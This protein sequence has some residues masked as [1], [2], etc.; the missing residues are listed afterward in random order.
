MQAGGIAQ[1]GTA[2]G[3]CLSRA[4]AGRIHMAKSAVGLMDCGHDIAAGVAGGADSIANEVGRIMAGMTVRTIRVAIQT[5]LFNRGATHDHIT[6]RGE[7]CR[8]IGGPGGVMT[9]VHPCWCRARMPSV[10]LQLVPTNRGLVELVPPR[11]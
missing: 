2:V 6:N 11:R 10:P 8:D 3:A 1:Q 9:S 4:A 5:P 7:R